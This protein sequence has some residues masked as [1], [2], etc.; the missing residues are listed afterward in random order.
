MLTLH[1]N[2]L[3][4]IPLNATEL[5]A[6]A[7]SRSELE[8]RLGLIPSNLTLNPAYD[9][10][11]EFTEA[12][13][14]HVLPQVMAHPDQWLWY[15]HWLLVDS[16]LNRTVGGIGASGPPDQQGQ[17]MIG[18]FT[19]QA[20]EGQGYMSE[21]VGRFVAWLSEEPTLRAV[22]AD[23]PVE[24]RG[25]QRVL[26]KNGFVRTSEAQGEYRYCRATDHPSSNT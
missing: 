14:E 10:M 8:A 25:T 3:R 7:E 2:R 15:T 16:M 23:V 18:Y 26:E 11:A 17:T 20:F 5:K 24:H 13:Q 6:L 1:T 22:I 4:L 21:A 9:F 12:I 19:D